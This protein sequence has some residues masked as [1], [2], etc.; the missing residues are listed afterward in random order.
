MRCFVLLV[1]IAV[2]VS[3][4]PGA[5]TSVAGEWLNESHI[6]KSMLQFADDGTFLFVGGNQFAAAAVT[7]AY[8]Q[9][10]DS[11]T[12]VMKFPDAGIVT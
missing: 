5:P 10:S 6:D 3:C 7:G 12:L 2:L 11:L 8:S 1:L 4:K 9:T